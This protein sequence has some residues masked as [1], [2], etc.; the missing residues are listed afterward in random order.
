MDLDRKIRKLCENSE[1]YSYVK[2]KLSQGDMVATEAKY[3]LKCLSD[4]YKYTQRLKTVEN[5]SSTLAFDEVV[6]Y[7]TT[8]MKNDKAEENL[9]FL[10]NLLKMLVEILEEMEVDEDTV[11]INRTRLKS[12][13]IDK[14]PDLIC[15]KKGREIVFYKPSVAD[16]LVKESVSLYASDDRKVDEVVTSV[17]KIISDYI[18]DEDDKE[19]SVPEALVNFTTKILLGCSTYSQAVKHCSTV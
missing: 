18:S 16:S 5:V 2:A 9:L 1:K 10:K 3:H 15:S 4:F 6:K 14:F 13:I 11:S 12:T 8:W 17:R 7:I 19:D